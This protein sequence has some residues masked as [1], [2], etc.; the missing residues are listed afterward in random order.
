V[1]EPKFA[2]GDWRGLQQT[3]TLLR[4]R[5]KALE[6]ELTRVQMGQGMATMPQPAASNAATQ[7][8]QDEASMAPSYGGAYGSPGSH[9]P[10]VQLAI[11]SAT[12]AP[13][14]EA[15]GLGLDAD[16]EAPLLAAAADAAAA[17][18]AEAVGS[19]P[20]GH[21]SSMLSQL[22]PTHPRGG[23][24][25]VSGG[26]AG[27]GAGS[28]S[29]LAQPSFDVDDRAAAQLA[30][31]DSSKSMQIA[32]LNES[33]AAAKSDAE[34][35]KMEMAAAKARVQVSLRCGRRSSS[36][37]TSNHNSRFQPPLH[38]VSPLRIPCRS[39]RAS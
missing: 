10:P 11:D 28:A 8:H 9:A 30:A 14:D 5:V 24:S 32:R 31:R 13:A 27:A 19:G 16:E 29:S 3:V 35:A 1:N 12:G 7:P 26:G 34:R 37:R 20:S 15:F 18:F 17:R 33:V 23:A 21:A 38:N 4:A 2:P 39:S 6:R 22:P 36:L 25:V